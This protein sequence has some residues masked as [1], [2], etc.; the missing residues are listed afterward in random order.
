[1]P[2]QAPHWVFTAT[3]LS[4]ILVVF[5]T[6]LYAVGPVMLVVLPVAL[7]ALKRGAG[8]K[9]YRRRAQYT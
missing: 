2:Q 9:S 4:F 5:V 7:Y 8:S 1:V 6:L 3:F